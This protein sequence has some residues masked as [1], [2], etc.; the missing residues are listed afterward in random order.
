MIYVQ[1]H[2]IDCTQEPRIMP[3]SSDKGGTRYDRLVE[4]LATELRGDVGHVA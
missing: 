4:R 2:V 1:Q 3:T